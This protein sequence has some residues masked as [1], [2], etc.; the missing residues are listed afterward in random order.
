MSILYALISKNYNIIL[1]EYTDHTGNFQQITRILLYKLKNNYC[2]IGIIRYDKYIYSYITQD[3][4]IF[5]CM[6]N[7]LDEDI[8]IND[9][10]Y[11]QIRQKEI[12]VIISFLSDI[13]QRF[14]S[15]YNKAKIEQ[16]KAYEI[17]EFSQTINSLMNY[18]NNKQNFIEN[19]NSFKTNINEYNQL[20]ID[21]ISNYLDSHEIINIIIINNDLIN[22]VSLTNKNQLLSSYNFKRKLKKQIR[23]CLR[24]IICV[25]IF[26]FLIF[27]MVNIFGKKEDYE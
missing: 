12:N 22:N 14:L 24:I 17:I 10:I 6:S 3:N 18:Y 19:N 2:K 20:R 9:N 23:I 26:F 27:L 25:F 15:K 21:N 11:L 7:N 16:M 8:T 1:T 4:L 13:K 5:L